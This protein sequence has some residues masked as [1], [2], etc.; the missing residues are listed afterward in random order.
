[1]SRACWP[2]PR[3]D[4][5][6]PAPA[7]SSDGSRPVATEYR[8][9]R[10]SDASAGTLGVPC[11]D[12]E[13]A[14]V[15]PDRNR[16]PDRL[17]RGRRRARQG[18]CR[19]R[20]LRV[21][22]LRVAATPLC[23]THRGGRASAALPGKEVT[24]PQKPSRPTVAELVELLNEADTTIVSDHRG[25][26]VADLSKVRR[27]LREKDISYRVVKNRLAQDRCR[28]GRTAGAHPA[29]HRPQRAGRRWRGRDGAGQGPPGRHPALQ[30]ARSA[31]PP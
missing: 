4:G 29:A 24:C 30:G 11:R 23:G 17:A 8:S 21:R 26:S 16:R 22:A 14:V 5:S 28:A 3:P 31:A 13:T 10:D 20:D 27:D 1:M 9:A 7:T 19:D 2:G 12:R 6:G 15:G 25:L 18:R